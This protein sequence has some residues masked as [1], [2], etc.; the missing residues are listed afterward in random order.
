MPARAEVRQAVAVGDEPAPKS[1][2]FV[3]AD[4]FLF[5]CEGMVSPETERY[6]A[7]LMFATSEHDVP[8]EVAGRREAVAI[9]VLKPFVPKTLHADA[10]SFVSVAI[11][12]AHP[13]YRA[14][15][16]LADPG[17]I[18][19]PRTL[20][21]A[22]RPQLDRLRTLQAGIADA[23]QFYNDCIDAVTGLM[24]PLRPMDPRIERTMALLRADHRQPLEAL[25]DQVCLSYY[26]LSHL[27][28]HEMGISLRQYVLSLKIHAACR[29]IGMGLSLTATAHE[30]GFTD[31]AHL[32][33]VWAKAFGGPPSLFMNRQTIAIQPAPASAVARSLVQAA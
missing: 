29:C 31:S 2:L 32:S 18:A 5:A 3:F 16:R 28:S 22:L 21:P 14:F 7:T 27:F 13:K 17:Y 8:I 20:F 24:P 4:G 19:M 25:A 26:R 1:Q 30:A 12:P 33:R 23:R 11:N 10:Q 9:A 15:T 6:T